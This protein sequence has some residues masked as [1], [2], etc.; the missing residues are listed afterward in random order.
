QG[1]TGAAQSRDSSG[2][3]AAEGRTGHR[4]GVLSRG[5]GL[6]VFRGLVGGGLFAALIGL[7]L[8]AAAAGLLRRRGFVRGGGVLFRAVGLG[9]AEDRDRVPADVDVGVDRNGDL[10]V[11]EKA[12]ARAV[13]GDVAAV[14]HVVRGVLQRF[15]DG[16]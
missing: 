8:L 10:V 3:Q 11:V 7:G 13:G 9:R 6:G 1:R 5:S 2:N 15:D 4:Q 16:V 14:H 12:A